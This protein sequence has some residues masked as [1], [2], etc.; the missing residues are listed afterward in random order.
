M[1]YRTAAE[2]NVSELSFE[3]KVILA[4]N[5]IPGPL[6]RIL[7]VLLFPPLVVLSMFLVPVFW[8][9]FG[10]LEKITDIVP[11][12]LKKYRHVLHLRGT[13]PLFFGDLS[14]YERVNL[15]EYEQDVSCMCYKRHEAK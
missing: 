6:R 9:I 10:D 4:K 5:R 8:I 7:G 2:K 3:E 13:Y 11:C 14:F 12:G 15:G 1:P